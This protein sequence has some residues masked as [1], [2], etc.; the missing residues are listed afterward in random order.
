M[1]A[2]VPAPF[3]VIFAVVAVSAITSAG[4]L[5]ADEYNIKEKYQDK[6]DRI[7]R[8][9]LAGN[10]AQ[11]KITE[12]CDD[13]G[14]RISGSEALD[15]AC[16]WAAETMRADGQEE[17]RL[18]SVSIPKWVRGRESAT[19]LTPREAPLAMLGL[20]GSVATPPGGITAPVIVARDRD[21]LIAKGE[22]ARGKIVLFN[23]AMPQYSPEKGTGYGQ[24]VTYRYNGA[25]WAAQQGAVACLV[26]SVTANSL[27]S[28]HTGGM[29]YQ[30]AT[31]KIP[32]AAISVEDAEMIA[33]LRERG[34]NVT[35]ELKM[36]AKDYGETPGANVVGELRGTT[37]PDEIVVIGGHIDSWDVGQGAHDDGGGCAAAME[38]L[39]VLRKMGLR[40]RRTIRVVLWTAEEVGLYGAKAY[41]KAHADELDRHVAAI[42]SDIGSFKPAGYSMD[43]KDDR[44]REI[45]ERQMRE[46]LSMCQSIGPLDLD[47]G[48]AAADVSPMKEAGVVIMG[49]NSDRSQ[50]F[51]YHHTHADTIDKIN[52]IELSQNVAVMATVAYVIAD[53]PPRLGED[54][55]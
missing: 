37:H 13:I 42:E 18:E 6:A 30:D 14:H 17:V 25:K 1:K 19:M 40:P 11:T 9:V 23:H 38:A 39:N 36:E 7:I 35:V 8:T 24:T 47:V 33:R 5:R 10:D 45:A 31:V 16:R 28:P 53:M 44:K 55:R 12:L 51:D 15:R 48:F 26:R 50:Y 21:E 4:P 27:R 41:A 29:G 20:G 43:C 46:I 22:A 52:P 2:L 54:S 32:T 49:H 34:K 3:A